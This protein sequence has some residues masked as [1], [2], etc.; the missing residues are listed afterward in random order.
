MTTETVTPRTSPSFGSKLAAET[1]GTF[2]LVFGLIG[3]ATF[4]ATL[5][6]GAASVGTL[7]ACL[8]LGFAVIIGAYAFGPISGGHFNPAVTLGLAAAGRLPWKNTLPYIIAQLIGGIIATT[9]I[10]LLA[11]GG[12]DGF[13]K[14]ATDSGFISNGFGDQSPGGFGLTSAIIIETIFT[15]IF[16]YVILG[17]THTR[18]AAGFA[19]IAIGLTLTL[20]LMILIPIDNG[21][22]NPARSIATAIYGG[23]DWLAQVWVFIIFPILGALIAGFS[24]RLIFDRVTSR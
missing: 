10:Y 12:P 21:S 2:L 19:P 1:T 14:T 5:D 24:S 6:G 22:V 4:A 15:A 23:P 11:L 16:I 3:T 13:A 20:M 8:A 7:G 9:L 18:A 17:V